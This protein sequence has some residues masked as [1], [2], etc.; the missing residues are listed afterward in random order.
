M[1]ITEDKL[2]N[3][4]TFK[5]EQRKIKPN[6]PWFIYCIP[7]WVCCRYKME[8]LIKRM[9]C[10]WYLVNILIEERNI[11]S[12]GVNTVKALSQIINQQLSFICLLGH[13]ITELLIWGWKKIF[14]W[15]PQNVLK[16]LMPNIWVL[17]KVV[18][19]FSHFKSTYIYFEFIIE[20]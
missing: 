6:F 4:K 11:I 20:I 17:D 13:K 3:L 14:L 16:L 5:L 9:H 12:N 8:K 7:L 15:V 18:R 19:Y 10:T 2:W 1:G